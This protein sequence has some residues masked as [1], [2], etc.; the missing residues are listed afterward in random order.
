[1]CDGKFVPSDAKNWHERERAVFDLNT[2]SVAKIVY[3]RRWM[4]EIRV[5]SIGG[6]AQTEGQQKYWER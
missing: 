5:L 4:N 1:M 2:L 6:M 3:R